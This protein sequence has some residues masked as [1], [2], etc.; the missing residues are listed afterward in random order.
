[1]TVEKSNVGAGG[2]AMNAM[3]KPMMQSG[4]CVLPRSPGFAGA[5]SGAISMPAMWQSG[6]DS[7]A[8]DA[9]SDETSGHSAVHATAMS[10]KVAAS[11]RRDLTRAF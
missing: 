11:R 3:W 5:W 6:I 7:E 1:M 2:G 10:A 9:S 8:I 4:Q